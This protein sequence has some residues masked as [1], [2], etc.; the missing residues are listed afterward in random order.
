MLTIFTSPKV[1]KENHVSIIQKNAIKSWTKIQPKCEIILFGDDEGVAEAADELGV[2]HIPGIK[3]NEQGT[4]I[5]NSAISIAAKEAKSQI[6][7]YVNSDIILLNDIISAIGKIKEKSFLISG[8][9]WDIDIKEE[10]DFNNSD[11][12]VKLIEKIKK[13]G[14][15]H[16]L[17][18]M[19]YFVF[20]RQLPNMI[21]MPDFAV[22]R[23]GWD[24]WLI[25]RTRFLKIP[26]IDA[27][28]EI[29]VIHQNHDYSHSFYGRKKQVGGPE[30]KKTLI[31][32][33]GLSKMCT[34]RDA[35]FILTKN[36]IEKVPFPRLIF[37]KLALFRPWRLI[38]AFKRRLF[39]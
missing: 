14:K 33:G 22:G 19:D 6:L 25:Y 21:K 15:L 9:R 36:G 8:Q 3:K 28:S 34:L 32:A 11:W 20:P 7:L 24:N 18:G 17:A 35:D 39:S 13:T 4:P 10:I 2:K 26:M 27:T 29:T 30:V 23:A 5:L 31:L 38:L 37:S 16:G 1:F 12:E